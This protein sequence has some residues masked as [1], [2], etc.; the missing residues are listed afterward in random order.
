MTDA[1]GQ[2]IVF[3]APAYINDDTKQPLMF[4]PT[5]KLR[6][7]D[8]MTIRLTND[9][10]Q[11]EPNTGPDEFGYHDP[12]VRH[13]RWLGLG[14]GSAARHTRDAQMLTFCNTAC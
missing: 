7:G 11:L 13:G 4:G 1:L 6:A 2:V 3:T 5:I 12:M 14:P 8:T 10:V 9:L